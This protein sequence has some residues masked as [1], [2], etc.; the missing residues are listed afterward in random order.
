[1]SRFDLYDHPRWYDILFARGSAAKIRGLVRV[2]RDWTESARHPAWLEPACGTGRLLVPAARRGISV[3][4][5]DRSAAMVEFAARQ[6]AKFGRKARVVEADLVDAHRQLGTARFDLAFTLDNSL[7]HLPDDGAVAAHLASTARVLKPGGAYVV[8]LS[9]HDPGRADTSED[10][11]TGQRGKTR[12]TQM[13]QFEP[14]PAGSRFRHETVIEHVE[15]SDAAG[16]HHHDAV[17]RLLLLEQARWERLVGDS[18][19]TWVATLDATGSPIE[20]GVFDYQWLVLTPRRR[21]TSGQAA[22][23][24]AGVSRP[25]RRPAVAR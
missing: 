8:G 14:P 9:F 12:V 16:A 7:R 6:L 15:V 25:I 11:W 13:V 18:P 10:I 23:R 1:M 3:T 22:S 4:G 5:Y 21:S 2:A 20:P 17:W 19:F 24:H